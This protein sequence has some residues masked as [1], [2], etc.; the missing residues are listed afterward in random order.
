VSSPPLGLCFA[1]TDDG[2]ILTTGTAGSS[3]TQEAQIDGEL[4]GVACPGKI[5]VR[6]IGG[7]ISVFENYQCTAVGEDGAILSKVVDRI[8]TDKPQPA[9]LELGSH[10]AH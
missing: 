8:I 9:D 6:E 4:L 5:S 3:W 2:K 10:Q 7:R 1:V